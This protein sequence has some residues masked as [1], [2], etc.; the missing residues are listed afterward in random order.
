MIEPWVVFFFFG[1]VVVFI[2]VIILFQFGL[3]L[4]RK[5]EKENYDKLDDKYK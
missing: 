5:A 1:C 2:L 4:S 3:H